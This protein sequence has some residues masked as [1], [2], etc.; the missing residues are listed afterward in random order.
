MAPSGAG[1]LAW[2]LAG[3]VVAVLVAHLLPAALAA[4]NSTNTTVATHHLR[5]QRYPGQDSD[6]VLSVAASG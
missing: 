6:S 2:P 4:T 1:P 5:H 3:L